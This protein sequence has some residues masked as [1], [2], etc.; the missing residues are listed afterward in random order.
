MGYFVVFLFLLSRVC[1]QN[2]QIRKQS[3]ESVPAFVYQNTK[4]VNKRGKI[5]RALQRAHVFAARKVHWTLRL[6]GS[7]LRITFARY[8]LSAKEGRRA[9]IC[10]PNGSKRE[11][12]RGSV[13]AFVSIFAQKGNKC[14]VVGSRQKVYLKIRVFIEIPRKT[15]RS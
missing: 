4:Y 9:R 7:A 3:R 10:L 11:Q 13:P 6:S 14:G 5:A 15:R 1:F 2:R 12:T 8:A